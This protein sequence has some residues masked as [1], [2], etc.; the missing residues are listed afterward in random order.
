MNVHF[1]YRCR[2]CNNTFSMGSL[3]TF[4][5]ADEELNAIRIAA[6]GQSNI[7][8]SRRRTLLSL[9]GGHHDCK[10]V[11]KGLADLIGIGGN[12]SPQIPN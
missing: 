2:A 4:E 7:R 6:S 3:Y 12:P 9:T 5:E 8:V 1:I 11:M 10:V